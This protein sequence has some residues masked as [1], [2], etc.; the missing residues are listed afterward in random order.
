MWEYSAKPL[1]AAGAWR[2]LCGLGR[3]LR[4]LI[5]WQMLLQTGLRLP[6]ASSSKYPE[7]PTWF[8]ARSLPPVRD[9]VN[10]CEC[11]LLSLAARTGQDKTQRL[12]RF[13]QTWL[14]FSRET[15]AFCCSR[16]VLGITR[17]A[18]SASALHVFQSP[19]CRREQTARTIVRQG[20]EFTGFLHNVGNSA[21]YKLTDGRV[22]F[23]QAFFESHPAPSAER[24]VQQCCENILLNAAWLKRDADNIHQYFLQ[25]KAPPAAVW[26][27]RSC[28]RLMGREGGATRQPIHMPRIWSLFLKP[29]GIGQWM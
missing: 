20:A 4:N 13:A 10:L 22:L 27:P 28:C 6:L 8:A 2:S 19:R 29:M 25:R 21:T 1:S 26:A 3:T 17:L 5:P 7:I 15:G 16:S 18:N 23:P 11:H 14:F 9:G 24:T 12:G